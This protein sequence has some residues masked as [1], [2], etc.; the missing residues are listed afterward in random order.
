ME[1]VNI[2]EWRLNHENILDEVKLA[3]W[4]D[5]PVAERVN[6]PVL[7]SLGAGSLS[8]TVVPVVWPIIRRGRI[9]VA[10]TP[11]TIT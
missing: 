11:S 10:A 5:P 9:T 8:T 4:K 2:S 6:E 1:A 7:M 3:S